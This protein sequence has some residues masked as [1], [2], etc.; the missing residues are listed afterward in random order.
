M[1]P[2]IAVPRIARGIARFGSFVSS[3]SVAAASKPPKERNPNTAPRNT[4]DQP[5][6]G[7]KV[8]TLSVKWWPDGAVPLIN[9]TAI[10]TV[11]SRISAM[12]ALSMPSSR[13]VARRAGTTASSQ[14][15]ISATPT[16]TYGAQLGGLG[17][18][19]TSLR[20]AVPRLP[21]AHAVTTAKNVYTPSRP[22]PE[23]TP[24]REPSVAPTN[25]YTEPACW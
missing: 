18:M 4:P 1:P 24:A 14:Q 9:R 12:V 8:N 20:N 7:L 23:T 16:S 19:P 25:A 22:M 2:K 11:T 21:A 13:L 10:T 15:P 5:V 3:P 6:P 17:Q